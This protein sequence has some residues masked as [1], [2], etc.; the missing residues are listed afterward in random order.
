MCLFVVLIVM[1][2]F[3]T[4]FMFTCDCNFVYNGMLLEVMVFVLVK[5]LVLQLILMIMMMILRA[6]Y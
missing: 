4:R 5:V 3:V 6:M 2:L 1:L